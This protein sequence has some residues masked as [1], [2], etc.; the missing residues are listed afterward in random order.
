MISTSGVV[1]DWVERGTTNSGG[2]PGV[3]PTANS[4]APWTG[5]PSTEIARQY[6]RYHPRGRC[7]LSGTTSVSGFAGERLTG[8]VVTSCPRASLTEIVANRG[9]TAS[10]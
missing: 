5:W 3:G 10:S 4:Y 1:A 8:A 6:T 7:G 9:S 2:A